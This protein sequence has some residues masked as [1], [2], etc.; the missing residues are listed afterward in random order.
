[1][2]YFVAGKVGFEDGV[3]GVI[4]DL[5]RM[6]HEV[7]LDWRCLNVQKPYSDNMLW[8]SIPAAVMREAIHN[9]D[10]FILV[11]HADLLGGILETGMAL[12]FGIPVFIIR[13][14]YAVGKMRDSIYWCLG[15]VQ[16]VNNVEEIVR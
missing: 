3:G 16:I 13:P 14:S 4:T 6:G 10:A 11:W 9:A 15:S 12:A 1:M 5:E 8:N 2:K 7:T